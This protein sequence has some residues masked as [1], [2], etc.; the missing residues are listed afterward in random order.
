MILAV[1]SD[2]QTSRFDR[3]K[4]ESNGFAQS[5]GVDVRDPILIADS[6]VREVEPLAGNVAIGIWCVVSV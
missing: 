5:S 6:A 1:A 3:G 2:P 4:T